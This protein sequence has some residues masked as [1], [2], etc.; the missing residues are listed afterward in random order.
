MTTLNSEPFLEKREGQR[1]RRELLLTFERWL[2]FFYEGGYAFFQVF[3]GRDD[4]EAFPLQ[5]QC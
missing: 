1:D 3:R 5:R 2:S 4:A